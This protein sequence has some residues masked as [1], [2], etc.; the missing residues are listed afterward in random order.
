MKR[1][2]V[3]LSVLFVSILFS[4][5]VISTAISGLYRSFSK[6]NVDRE[7]QVKAVDKQAGEGIQQVSAK[8]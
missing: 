5:V 6:P 4:T 3:F 7:M 1:P 8:I 2:V